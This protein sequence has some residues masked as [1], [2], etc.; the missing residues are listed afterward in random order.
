MRALS[1]RFGRNRGGSESN[2]ADA[3]PGSKATDDAKSSGVGGV[4]GEAGSGVDENT[5]MLES[6]N[7]NRQSGDKV[8]GR[9]DASG[10]E[11]DGDRAEPK[12]VAGRGRG[13][14]RGDKPSLELEGDV[15]MGSK[16]TSHLDNIDANAAQQGPMRVLEPIRMDPLKSLQARQRRLERLVAKNTPEIHFVG[17]ISSGIGIIRD[18]TEGCCCRW[19]VEYGK[20]WDHLGGELLGQTQTAYCNAKDTELIPFNHPIDLHFSEAGLHGWGAPR[21]AMQTYRLDMYGRMILVGYGFSH[22]PTS[23]GMHRLEI[24]MW[25]PIGSP[26]QELD[27]FLLG[28]TPALISPEPIYEAAWKDR[29]RLVTVSAGKVF[30]DLFIVT[31]FTAKQGLDSTSL[32][33]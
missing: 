7:N 28:R 25:R 26:E 6:G 20:A 27:A 19:K 31:R 17:Q 3:V 5:P 30:V 24:N 15:E 16:A 12:G 14:A 18:T 29:C 1:S 33:S 11:L 10:S 4:G 2:S 8:G 23:P 13:I 9:E 32:V 21:L 22:L